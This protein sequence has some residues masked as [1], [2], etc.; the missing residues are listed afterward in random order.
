V[1]SIIQHGVKSSEL[2]A[3]RLSAMRG[4]VSSATLDA[5]GLDATRLTFEAGQPVFEGE[6][7]RREIQVLA[8]GIVGEVRI[9]ADGRRQILALRFPGDALIPSD[10]EALVALTRVRTAD[11]LPLMTRLADASEDYQPLR[12]AWVAAS[13]TDQAI[14]RDQVVRLGRMSAFERMAHMLLEAHERLAQVG[15]ATDT[16][17]H[18]P[19]TQEMVSDVIGLSV[20]HLNRTLQNLRRSELVVSKQGYVTLVDRPRL[21][22]IASYVSRFPVAWRPI[23]NRLARRMA[24]PRHA[25]A[26]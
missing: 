2:L 7:I 5:I 21:V 19:L 9:L 4:R 15:L 23:D 22:D 10:G 14:L 3:R 11:G 1:I 12:R 13:R 26:G 24:P 17:F 8:G 6:D 25:M 18:L 16:T 20:V